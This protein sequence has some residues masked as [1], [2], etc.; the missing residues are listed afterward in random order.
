MKCDIIK[1]CIKKI[2]NKPYVTKEI[3]LVKE[4]NELIYETYI[5][6]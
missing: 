4:L 6:F 1:E 2:V 5:N 3:D